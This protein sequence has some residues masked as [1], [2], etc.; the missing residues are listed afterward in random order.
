MDG[1]AVI[2]IRNV[3]REG[4]R[5]QTLGCHLQHDSKATPSRAESSTLAWELAASPRAS[6]AAPAPPAADWGDVGSA[7]RGTNARVQGEGTRRQGSRFPT[8]PSG[9]RCRNSKGD[10]SH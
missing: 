4:G 10:L 2:I 5:W 7:G 3:K 9:F 1:L 8:N 6:T